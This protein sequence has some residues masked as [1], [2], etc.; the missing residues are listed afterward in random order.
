MRFIFEISFIYIGLKYF[1]VGI[2]GAVYGLTAATVLNFLVLIPFFA[3]FYRFQFDSA[4]LKKMLLFGLPLVPNA[5]MYLFIEIED[6]YFLDNFIDKATQAAYTNMYK[7]AAILTV[8][9]SAFRAAFQ[10]L[11]LNEA[12]EGN[13]AY[14]RQVMTYFLVLSSFIMIAA[15]LLAVD[16]IRYNPLE[17]IQSLIRDEFYYSQTNLL[18]LI[19]LGYLFLGMYYNFSVAYYFKKKSHVF[20]QFTLAGLVVNFG[21]N[22]LMISFPEYGTLISA[23]ATALAYF[24]MA[25]FSYWRSRSIFHI[26]Y[27][28]THILIIF[29]YVFFVTYIAVFQSEISVF[30]KFALVV[31][32]LPYL[33]VLNVIEPKHLYLAFLRRGKN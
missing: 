28:M 18:A 19:L 7:F 8:V 23:S 10:P 22:S 13:L 2:M 3:R 15:S 16:F 21:L 1:D 17:M 5:V 4:Y 33:I 20:L 9:N 29:A 30:Y 11:M 31:L 26:K 6:R 14:F 27:N 32:Y 24:V 25:F 12:K